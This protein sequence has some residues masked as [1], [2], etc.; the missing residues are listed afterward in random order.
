MTVDLT[1]AERDLLK[2]I[3]DSYLSE[4]RHDIAATKRDTDTLHAEERVINALQKK[5]AETR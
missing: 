2:K 5:L 4:L 3:L 1:T